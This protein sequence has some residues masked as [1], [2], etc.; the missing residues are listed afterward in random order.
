M[1]ALRLGSLELASN[2]LLAPLERV[3]DVGFRRLCFQ[4]GAFGMTFTEMIYASELAKGKTTALQLIDTHDSATLTGI[5]LL[6]DRTAA[7]DNYG[8]DTLLRALEYL[9]TQSEQHPHWKNMRAIDLNFGCPSPGIIR[10]GAGPGQ[11]R[12]RSKIRNIF[13]TLDEW[14]RTTSLTHIQAV[15]AKIRLGANAT[16]QYHKV[17][18]PVVEAAAEHLDYVTVHARHA[19]QKSRDAPTWD[20]ITEVQQAVQGSP[21]VVIGNGDART[22]EDAL[23]MMD[24]TQCQGVMVGRGAMAN[25]WWDHVPTNEEVLAGQAEYEAWSSSR[26]AYDRYRTFHEDNFERLI[27]GR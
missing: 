4:T 17:Y 23:K 22:P 27:R 5:Q 14:R 2:V 12:R 7:K 19:K 8:V 24:H 21:L 6:V 1:A 25:P 18:L 13:A 16:E 15:G 26:P 9:E 10:R 3:S 20:A 11:L